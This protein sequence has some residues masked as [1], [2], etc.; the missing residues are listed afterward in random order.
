MGSGIFINYGCFWVFF[1]FIPC[2]VTGRVLGPISYGR[3]QGPPLDGLPAYGG[4]RYLA[5]R[6]FGSALMVYLRLPCYQHT[7]GLEPRTLLF[8]P[9]TPTNQC[10]AA[11][12]RR[13]AI[14]I[15]QLQQDGGQEERRR[16]ERWRN[17]AQIQPA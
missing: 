2:R 4:G 6:H 15:D 5:Q 12:R 16:E 3:R 9:S 7:W 10:A 13:V 11:D 1:L 17:R 14:R 8:Q